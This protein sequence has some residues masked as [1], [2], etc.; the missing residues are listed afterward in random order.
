MAAQQSCMVQKP[1]DERM[2][3]EGKTLLMAGRIAGGSD[4]Q[5]LHKKK[6]KTLGS[7]REERVRSDP[8]ERQAVGCEKEE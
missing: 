5:W 6:W 1:T 2:G 7:D 8:S 4:R 3:K